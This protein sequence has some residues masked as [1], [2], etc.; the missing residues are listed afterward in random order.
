M[1][2]SGRPYFG[3]CHTP[4]QVSVWGASTGTDL[5]GRRDPSRTPRPRPR[6]SADQP[7]SMGQELQGSAR[8]LPPPNLDRDVQQQFL[9]CRAGGTFGI[10]LPKG[11]VMRPSSLHVA[12]RVISLAASCFRAC[13]SNCAIEGVVSSRPQQWPVPGRGRHGNRLRRSRRGPDLPCLGAPP[14]GDQASAPPERSATL[15]CRL[16]T[17]AVPPPC[18]SRPRKSERC[19]ATR[20][21][22]PSASTSTAF[23]PLDVARI[24]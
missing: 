12:L 17:R 3:F 10:V 4:H 1:P 22:A 16:A 24:T 23:H 19:T 5:A 18:L 2:S 20:L 21:I 15:C 7:P 6:P 11:L 14:V 8:R 9:D 13:S